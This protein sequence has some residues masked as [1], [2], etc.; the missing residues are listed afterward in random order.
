MAEQDRLAERYGG[1]GS[2]R[3]VFP[4]VAAVIVVALAGWLGWVIWDRADPKVTSHL[5]TW[6]IV[7]AHRATAVVIVELPESTTGA[8]CKLRAYAEDHVTV[9]EASFTPVDGSQE[10]TIRTEREATSVE[11]V[12]CTADGQ[13]YVR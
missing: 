7:D 9:G 3:W 13:N 5:E 6:E 11:M 1:T 4:A 8:T 12:G 10:V 2:L